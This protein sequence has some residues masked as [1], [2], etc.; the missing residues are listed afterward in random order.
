MFAILFR[1]FGFIAPKYFCLELD[2]VYIVLTK[3][4]YLR[5]YLLIKEQCVNSYGFLCFY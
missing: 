3:I 1:S 4:L 2:E 5:S